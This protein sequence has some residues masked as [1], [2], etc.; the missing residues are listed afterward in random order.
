MARRHT[1]LTLSLGALLLAGVIVLAVPPLPS[2]A[3]INDAEAFC[4][5]IDSK[6]TKRDEL[7]RAVSFQ[8]RTVTVHE[9]EKEVVV[10]IGLCH[11]YVRFS[12]SGTTATK[13]VCNG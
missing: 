4:A 6:A 13:P 12:E 2:N 1:W 3:N 5:S 8:N 7:S 11:C 9:G 10:R